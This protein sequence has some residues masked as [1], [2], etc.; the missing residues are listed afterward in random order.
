MRAQL[1]GRHIRDLEVATIDESSPGFNRQGNSR[2]SGRLSQKA[3]V[4]S[5]GN[6]QMPVSAC[7]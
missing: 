1:G 4:K 2:L 7:A 5:E 6:P 3:E